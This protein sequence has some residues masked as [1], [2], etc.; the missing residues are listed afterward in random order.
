M[1]I[2]LYLLGMWYGYMCTCIQAHACMLVCA[3]MYTSVQHA[4]RN[5]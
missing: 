1:E 5:M 2:K 4:Y 3:Y